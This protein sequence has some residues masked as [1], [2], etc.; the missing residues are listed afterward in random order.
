MGLSRALAVGIDMFLVGGLSA[1]TTAVAGGVVIGAFSLGAAV[2]T[3]GISLLVAAT[4][5][6]IYAIAKSNWTFEDA[7]IKAVDQLL[8]LMELGKKDMIK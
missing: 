3:A 6:G 2:A 5:A 8:N 7:N 1:Y 4:A